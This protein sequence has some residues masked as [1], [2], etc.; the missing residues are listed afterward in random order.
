MSNTTARKIE[1]G[2]RSFNP[3]EWT[4]FAWEEPRLGKQVKGEVA[5]IRSLCTS[6]TLQAGLWRTGRGIA[7]CNPDGSC[8]VDYSAPLGD[9]TVVILEGSTTVTVK[10]TG[11]QYRLEAGSIMSHPKGLEITWDIDA[12][13]LK[14]FWVMWDSPT[15]ATKSDDVF[16]GSISDNPAE[17]AA[18]EWVEPAHGPQVCGELFM[19]RATGSTGTLMCGLWRTGVGIAGCNA[20]GSSTIPYTAPLGDETMFLLEGQA[21]LVNEETGEEYDFKAGDVI[22]LPSG[23]PVKW[24][25]KGPFVKKFWIITNANLPR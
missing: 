20:D 25:S 22:A 4:P 19:L 5:V 12:P 17:W 11:K 9:E 3:A 6:G 8:H 16:V 7:G 15:P 23:L 2:N 13:F 10:A 24:T 1:V 18:Y 14:K 21:H